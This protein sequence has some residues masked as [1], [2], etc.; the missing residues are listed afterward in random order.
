MNEEVPLLQVGNNKRYDNPQWYN[1]GDPECDNYHE[2][3]FK[4]NDY[5]EGDNIEKDFKDYDPIHEMS[6]FRKVL[7]FTWACFGELTISLVITGWP[8]FLPVLVA[9]GA[10]F[11]LCSMHIY[12]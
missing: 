12:F 8:A 5:P 11:E 2:N 1:E 9:D 10:F 6:T 3:D 7:A 4:D